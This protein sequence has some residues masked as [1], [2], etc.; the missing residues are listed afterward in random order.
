MSKRRLISSGSSF[1]EL[2]GYS[3]AVV[4]GEW[5]F[6]S[7]CTGFDYAAGT[8]SDDVVEQTRRTFRNIESAL[9]EAGASLADVVRVRVFLD[10]RDDFPRVA[11]ELGEHFGD[12]R[13]ANTTVIAPLVDSRMKVEIEVTARTRPP[14]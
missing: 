9:A 11:P 8:I 14:G 13:P 7:G 4:D 5:V 3:R 6:V 10:S 2:A 1:E 12:I